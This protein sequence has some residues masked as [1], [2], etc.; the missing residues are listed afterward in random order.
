[1]W[2][3]KNF[4]KISVFKKPFK[5]QIWYSILLFG[6]HDTEI[7]TVSNHCVVFLAKMCF[8]A[9]KKKHSILIVL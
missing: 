1:M 3:L 6:F 8:L 9:A 5:I 2:H 4:Q 7:D